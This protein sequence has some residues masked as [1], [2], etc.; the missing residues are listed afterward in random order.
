VQKKK[1]KPSRKPTRLVFHYFHSST[2]IARS[3]DSSVSIVTR[4]RNWRL[5]LGSWQEEGLFLFV[6]ASISVMWLTHPP[7]QWV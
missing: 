7:T 1:K 5:G 6:T 4:L 3:R 2:A